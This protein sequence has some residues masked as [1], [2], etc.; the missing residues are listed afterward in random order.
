[1]SMAIF[2]SFL[3]V[4]QRVSGLHS[5]SSQKTCYSYGATSSKDQ[6]TKNP[7]ESPIDITELD[8]WND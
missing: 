6:P 4:Y 2:N 8:N 1:M 7:E 5:P 3:Y